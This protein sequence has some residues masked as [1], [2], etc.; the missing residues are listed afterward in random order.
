M[1]DIAKENK[2][3]SFNW[4]TASGLSPSRISDFKRLEK[5]TKAGA[6]EPEPEHD[7]WRH[8]FSL[9]NFITLWD[10]LRKLLEDMALKRGLIR[11]LEVRKLPTKVRVFLRLMTFNNAQLKLVDNFTDAV[12]HRVNTGTNQNDR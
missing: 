4:A 3:K 9:N 7:V 1:A 11:Q 2:V 10:G 12:L 6:A 5:K 8:N